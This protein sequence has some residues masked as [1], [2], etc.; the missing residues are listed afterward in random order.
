MQIMLK[1]IRWKVQSRILTKSLTTGDTSWKETERRRNILHLE[2]IIFSF[3]RNQPKY[4]SSPDLQHYRKTRLMFWSSRKKRNCGINY[5]MNMI[6]NLK[7]DS[8]FGSN[9]EETNYV[10]IK[11]HGIL[12]IQA[13]QVVNSN[14]ILPRDAKHNLYSTR[15]SK[16][17][18]ATVYKFI[19]HWHQHTE[20]LV[21]KIPTDIEN[22]TNTKHME[23][24][25]T[26]IGTGFDLQLR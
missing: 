19:L 25:S 18:Q 22:P 5:I 10:A 12:Q 14:K 4:Y 9:Q 3:K 23:L 8:M 13:K 21:S 15:T 7:I 16:I 26:P 24:P 11:R 1:S 17:L 20:K 2:L 6:L